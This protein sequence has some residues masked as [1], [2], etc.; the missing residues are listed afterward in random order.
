M[1][2]V[3]KSTDGYYPTLSVGADQLIR[4]RGVVV[5]LDPRNMR[6]RAVTWFKKACRQGLVNGVG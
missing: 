3:E 1:W 2:E 4:R 6:K 5:L